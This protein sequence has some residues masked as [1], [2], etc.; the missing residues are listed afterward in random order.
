MSF[1]AKL[2]SSQSQI[3]TACHTEVGLCYYDSQSRRKTCSFSFFYFGGSLTIA[4]RVTKWNYI[5]QH[6]TAWHLV[7]KW[8]D[9]VELRRWHVKRLNVETPHTLGL[10]HSDTQTYMQ[11]IRRGTVLLTYKLT[12]RLLLF[13]FTPHTEKPLRP[14]PL[15]P[16]V[17]LS[18]LH[19]T[20]SASIFFFST[21]A[22]K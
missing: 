3:Y 2:G 1:A 21:S 19:C 4:P 8:C 17:F 11:S 12:T 7:H 20:L 18:S 6:F 9:G 13:S 14:P 16:W 15:F 10:A 22:D 5:Q